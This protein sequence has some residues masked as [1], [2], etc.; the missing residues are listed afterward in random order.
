MTEIAAQRHFGPLLT[1]RASLHKLLILCC[2][3]YLSGAHWLVLQTTAWTGMLVSRSIATSV[4]DAIDTTF[5]GQ[6]PCAMCSAIADG[7]QAE[8]QSEQSF[9]L[10]KKVGDLKFL[11]SPVVGLVHGVVASNVFWPPSAFAVLTRCEAP[12]TPPPLA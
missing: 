7:K 1:V 3:L 12:P 9:D 10:L 6:H 5:D 8:Q 4:S 11:G 2:A